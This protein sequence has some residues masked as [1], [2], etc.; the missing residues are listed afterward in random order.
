MAQ[1][2]GLHSLR[3]STIGVLESQSIYTRH[4]LESTLNN[5]TLGMTIRLVFLTIAALLVVSA[6]G[7]PSTSQ[8]RVT[9]MLAVIDA[10]PPA[11]IRF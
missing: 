9:T 4:L 2:P 1:A 6:F 10:G 5:I 8:V 3:E 11:P 7:L